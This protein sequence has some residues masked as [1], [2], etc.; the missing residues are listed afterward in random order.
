[1]EKIR[2]FQWLL[3]GWCVG[4]VKYHAPRRGSLAFRRKRAR[5]IYP[6][7]FTWPEVDSTRLLGFPAY[8][9]GMLTV[10]E[11]NLLVGEKAMWYGLERTVAATALEAP[12]IRILGIR[13]YD[14]DVYGKRTITELWTPYFSKHEK[15]YLARKIRLPR[16]EI[17]ELKRIFEEKKKKI[18][19][20]LDQGKVGE[21]RV[22][23]RT[24]PELTT[25]GKKKPELL[26]IKVGGEV[27]EAYRWALEN[28]GK[29]I[30]ITDVFEPGMFV[31]IIGVTKGK[32]FQ[33]VV[34]RFGVKLLP[35]KSK[36]G[37]RRLG[38]LGP[39]TPGRVMWTVPRAGQMGF[40]RRTEYNKQ[41]LAIAPAEYEISYN[42]DSGDAPYILRQREKITIEVEEEGEK[43]HKVFDVPALALN[44]SGGWSHYG[45]IRNDAVILRGSCM[46]PQK[47]LIILRWPIRAEVL[48]KPIELYEFYY[49]RERILDR[50]GIDLMF[51]LMT[52]R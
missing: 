31:D 41:I 15:K 22:I 46:G 44:P 52:R 32:G 48:K 36:K 19:E 24:S 18:E 43:K 26:E 11:K 23:V 10:K 39:W 14:V 8:K 17:G 12:P 9:V 42:F 30:R 35:P 3:D 5:R 21:I 40:F 29:F 25:I 28:L 27:K 50:A 16:G 6:R 51:T 2:Y 13:V 7:I 4:M 49:G 20:L 33:G 47:R 34:K 38:S 1:M 37:I 45:V